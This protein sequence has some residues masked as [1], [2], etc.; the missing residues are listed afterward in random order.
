M[1]TRT[2]HLGARAG[3]AAGQVREVR[4]HLQTGAEPTAARPP[5]GTGGAGCAAAPRADSTRVP[6]T[7]RVRSRA[8]PV[9]C[10]D[11]E[12]RVEATVF[13]KGE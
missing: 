12:A 5:G 3:G 11:V 7:R 4:L 6:R 10:G 2:V 13:S 8:M 1:R 9:T